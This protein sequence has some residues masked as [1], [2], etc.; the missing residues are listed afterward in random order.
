MTD[1][2]PYIAMDAV[3]AK[4]GGSAGL[5]AR[6]AK[7]PYVGETVSPGTIRSWKTRGRVSAPMVLPVL[8][9]LRDAGHDPLSF[10]TVPQHGT[11]EPEPNPFEGLI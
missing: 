10:V 6:L 2:T 8:L 5:H 7:S 1:T 9:M 11:A 4:T 3:L